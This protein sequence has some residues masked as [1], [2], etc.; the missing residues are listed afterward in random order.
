MEN[1]NWP[2]L[3][4]V[5]I[6]YLLI[7]GIGIWAGKSKENESA[8]DFL[9]AS[10]KLPLWIAILTMA[11]TWIGGGYINGTAEYAAENGLVWV[12]APWGYAMSLIIGGIFF[13]RKMRRYRF[14]TMLDPL[15]QRYGSKATALFFIPAL[16]GEVFWIAAI[17]TA[18]GTTFAIIL[19]LS[20]EVAIIISAIV[21]IVYTTIGGL[22]SVAYT[23]VLQ[24]AMLVLGLFLVLPFALESVGDIDILWIAYQAKHGA[25]ASLFPSYEIM[26]N[27]YWNW[28]DFALLLML[29]G[30]P[31][32][33]YFQRV[34]A[35]RTENHAMW[36]SILAGVI[37][38][39]VAIPA[40]MI[41]MVGGV[42]DWASLGLSGP[43]NAAS[44]LPYV[45]QHLSSSW[46]A[47]VGMA[48]LAAAVMSSIDSSML[49]A[50][51]LAGWNVY[52]PLVRPGLS[53]EE[54]AK[55]VKRIIFIIGTAAT[56]LSLQVES[57]YALW[58]LCSD[59][60]YCLLFP[61]LVCALFDPRANRAGAV[62][63][64]AVAAFLRFGGGDATLGI[65]VLLPYPMVE[66]GVVLF[67]FRTLAMAAG[68]GTIMIVSR[69]T[70][71][72]YPPNMLKVCE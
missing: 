20:T 65:P 43:E 47:L 6:F 9:L 52:K 3:G 57:V 31:W 11:A 51:S 27:Y 5:L 53:S 34:L 66:D 37:C 12:Q 48:T 19:G 15:S 54:L 18:L 35:A 23:D 68:L 30:I 1:I 50:S 62:A 17:L 58:Y 36:L 33:V 10:R 71:R 70:Q 49:S 55:L 29:G 25:A 56:I 21:A 67:P 72:F 32:Q 26:G 61:A 8:D 38:I 24:M 7:F 45:F 13:A 59:F 16:M 39:I 42:I 28:W 4:M 40:A 46:V 22:K 41:G 14:Q 44:T 2:G 69:L 64:L 63:G 60:V